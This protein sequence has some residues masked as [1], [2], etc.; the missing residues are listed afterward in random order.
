MNPMELSE[1]LSAWR[2]RLEVKLNKDELKYPTDAYVLLGRAEISLWIAG[3]AN[4]SN[5][6]MDLHNYLR[7][8]CE[9]LRNEFGPYTRHILAKWNIHD[10]HDIANML[11]AMRR[12]KHLGFLKDELTEENV[13]KELDFKKEF[14]YDY[15]AEPPFP[16]VPSLTETD[17]IK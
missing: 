4:G 16:D 1:K 5:I 14:F 17:I 13:Q 7:F 12:I 2:S 11:F 3:H 10:A 15:A 6:M 8:F 9:R